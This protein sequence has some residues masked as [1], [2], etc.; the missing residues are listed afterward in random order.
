MIR[1][2]V[3]SGM[4]NARVKGKQIRRKPISKADLPAVFIKYYPSYAGDTMTVTELSRVCG[5]SR[6]TTYKY[7]HIIDKKA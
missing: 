1:A 5:L 4:A 7:I 6:P 3:R 2:R